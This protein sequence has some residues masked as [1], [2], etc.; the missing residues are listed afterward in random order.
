ML[1]HLRAR[2]VLVPDPAVLERIGLTARPRKTLDYAT[3]GEQFSS[4]LAGLAGTR[5][6]LPDGVRYGT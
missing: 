1:I 2:G 3:P 6:T 5:R 4:L